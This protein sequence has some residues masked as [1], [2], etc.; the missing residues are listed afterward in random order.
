M[1]IAHEVYIHCRFYEGCASG[2]SK[3]EKLYTIFEIIARAIKNRFI[4]NKITL[5]F[6]W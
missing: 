4:F 6:K 3:I 1:K 5:K 2:F